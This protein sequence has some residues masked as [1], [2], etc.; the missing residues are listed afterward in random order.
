MA[1]NNA[2]LLEA[3]HSNHMIT[4]FR[5]CVNLRVP[6]SFDQA[7][8]VLCL[9]LTSHKVASLSTLILRLEWTNVDQ[10]WAK[11][12]CNLKQWQHKGDTD[13]KLCQNRGLPFSL[14]GGGVG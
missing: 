12:G 11:Q 1:I 8:F 3:D 5:F 13:R 2:L 6:L 14:L 9:H 10:V 7:A 4:Y